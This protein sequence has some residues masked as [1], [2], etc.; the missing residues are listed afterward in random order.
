[1][2]AKEYL[3]RYLKLDVKIKI[4]EEELRDLDDMVTR[5]TP[6][7]KGERVQATPVS[8]DKMGEIV[9]KICDITIDL[10]NKREEA[11][12]ARKE[13]LETV[14]KVADKELQRILYFR[15]IKGHK[16]EQIALD[17]NKDYRWTL[18]LHGRALKEIEKILTMESHYKSVK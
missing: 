15:Y 13:I 2:C 4:L 9:A 7:L 12:V 1:M 5:V 10:I 14:L 17:V 18:R 3:R 6:Q 11:I 16:W 8:Q